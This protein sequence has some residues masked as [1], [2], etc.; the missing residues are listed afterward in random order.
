[1]SL[2]DAL[3]AQRRPASTPCL[4]GQMV[5]TLTGEDQKVLIH[6][7]RPDSGLTH[8]AISRA[9]DSEGHRL[10]QYSIGRHRKGECTCEPR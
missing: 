10:G 8:A 9:L 4:T 2:A 3:K 6:A 7:L 1:M 5:N